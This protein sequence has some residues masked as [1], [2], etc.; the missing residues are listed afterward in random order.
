MVVL[1]FNPAGCCV[2]LA[3]TSCRGCGFPFLVGP[4]RWEIRHIPPTLFPSEWTLVNFGALNEVF[5]VARVYF[6][7]LFVTFLTTGAQML[8]SAFTGYALAKFDFPG[9]GLLFLTMLATMMVPFFVVLVP[10][11]V[12]VAGWGW[13]DSYHG[14]I[15][16]G[17]FTP[18][19][20]FLLRQFSM[21]IPNDLLDAARIDG[22]SE[23]RVFFQIALPLL[24]PPMGALGIFAFTGTWGD[25]LWPL[26]MINKSELRTLPLALSTLTT[27]NPAGMGASGPGMSQLGIL[28][29][30]D[31]L[32][33]VPVLVVFFLFQRYI[34]EGVA[35]TGLAGR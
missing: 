12:M 24:G 34:T 5:P 28:L 30:G 23:L 7:S 1:V 3:D 17:L 33:V 20:I 26:F 10:L 14:L 27:V 31:L 21:T 22:A 15:I 18:F 16:P 4:V 35:L 29:A 9:R 11:F 2:H 6:N 13:I 8:T 32:A 25:F 19:G